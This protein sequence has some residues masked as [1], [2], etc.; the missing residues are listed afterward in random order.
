MVAGRGMFGEQA[1]RQSSHLTL[2]PSWNSAGIVIVQESG[3]YVTT[4]HPDKFLAGDI[5]IGDVMMGRRYCF[6][7]ALAAA[8]VGC[9][10]SLEIW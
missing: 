2:I 9:L 8:E 3:G 10:Q 1:S 5:S 7:R 4:G 6:V